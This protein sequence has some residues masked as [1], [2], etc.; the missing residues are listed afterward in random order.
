VANVLLINPPDDLEQMLGAGKVFIQ[1]Y[2]PL[3][4]LYIAAVLQEAG[5]DVT[6]VDCWAEGLDSE[7]LLAQTTALGPDVVG[8]SVL[9]CNGAAVFDLGRRVKRALPE[10]LVVFGNIHASVFAEPYLKAG[11][12]DVVVHGDGEQAMAAIVAGHTTGAFPAHLPGLSY[13]TA[14]GEINHT[15]DCNVIAD[16]K[17]LPLPARRLVKQELYG[18]D[19]ISN[20][21]WNA[22][23]GAAKTMI[24]SR[25]CVNRCTFCVVHGSRKPRYNSAE[26]VLNELEALERD[27]GASYVYIQDPLFLGHRRRT[28]EIC[29]GIRER[30]L[31][32]RWGCDA[33]VRDIDPATVAMLAAANC[34]ELSLGFESGVQRLLD[35]V[36]K[37]TTVEEG[38][39]AAETLKAHSDIQLEG[40]FI[41]G[42]PGE[43]PDDTRTTIRYAKALPID[44]AQFSLFTPYPG[45]PIFRELAER[46]AIDTGIRHDGTLDPSVWPRY[47]AYACFSG[48]E[49]IWVTAGHTAASLR[50]FQKQALREFY[51]RP[52]QVWRQVKRV[53]PG[54]VLTMARVALKG[55][56]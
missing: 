40:L 1:K 56:F 12:C 42:I 11:C 13:R 34:Y 44:M 33:H 23:S 31:T 19:H 49:P 50:A 2:E 46:R 16:L 29:A 53:R 26:N 5:H 30:G 18:L 48:I 45:S 21:L 36:N 9:T 51:L 54:N 24:T 3:G 27:F 28:R 22:G 37:R 38:V 25:G 10:T 4:L 43:T 6:V 47:S 39:R 15:P 55:F 20:Q 41:L 52:S 17:T 32:I 7:A 8:F 35:A 14:A